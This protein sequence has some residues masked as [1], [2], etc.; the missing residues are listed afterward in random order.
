MDR[1][2]R[3][4]E[5][6]A[7]IARCERLHRELE[8]GD[9]KSRAA[10]QT[11]D[12]GLPEVDQ[13]GELLRGY[14]NRQERFERALE[15]LL[16]HTGAA[17]GHL[18]AVEDGELTWVAPRGRPQPDTALRQRLQDELARCADEVATVAMSG[19]K[20]A[21]SQ[22]ATRAQASRER[23][24]LLM[25]DDAREPRV[26]AAASLAIGN[27]PLRAPSPALL[28]ALAEGLSA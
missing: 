9:R 20:T 1:W 14:K 15:I 11:L 17:S 18:F 5:N 4:T 2:L 23:P 7:L 13:L 10:L 6:P 28:T 12:M 21:D 3:P 19:S 16:E 26:V 8:A 25:L 22:L 24:Y 27:G